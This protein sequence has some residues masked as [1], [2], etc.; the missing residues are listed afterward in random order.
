MAHIQEHHQ[1]YVL[2]VK[3]VSSCGILSRFHLPADTEFDLPLLITLTRKQTNEAK[4]LMKKHPERYRFVEKDDPFDLCDLHHC[5]YYDLPFRA[6]CVR[7]SDN[8]FE[9]LLT[10]LPSDSFPPQALKEIYHM[11]WGIET[12]FRQLKYTI[13][14]NAFHTKKA[15][16]I[17]Q[18][19]YARLILFNFCQLVASHAALFKKSKDGS[20]TYKLNFSMVVGA[21][22]AL[23]KSPPDD[24]PDTIAAISRFLVPVR[25]GM[26]FERRMRQRKPMDAFYR[27]A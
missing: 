17:R 8:S 16:F 12:A 7:L 13:G 23:L 3:S 2:R 4:A 22:R 19:I 26:H 18:E 25:P 27:A 21:C 1:F 24:P 5:P 9:Y 20:R 15:E 6:V 11:R 14:L 10:N